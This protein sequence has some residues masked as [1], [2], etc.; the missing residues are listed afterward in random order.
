M[1]LSFIFLY[2]C[3][4]RQELQ[5]LNMLIV[6]TTTIIA[7]TRLLP[8]LKKTEERAPF[9]LSK[10]SYKYSATCFSYS[11]HFTWSE[12]VWTRVVLFVN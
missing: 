10:S 7:Y 2:Y 3:M 4:F 5:K 9:W 8:V 6:N 12:Q 1:F 11:S